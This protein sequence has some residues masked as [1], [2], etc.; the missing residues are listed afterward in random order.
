VPF[1]RPCRGPEVALRSYVAYGEQALSI[2]IARVVCCVLSENRWRDVSVVG[3]LKRAIRCA[4]RS[5]RFAGAFPRSTP[6]IHYDMKPSPLIT[7][8]FLLL[9]TASVAGVAAVSLGADLPEKSAK[10]R[11][12]E[13]GEALTPSDEIEAQVRKR[14]DSLLTTI[15]SRQWTNRSPKGCRGSIQR[16]PGIKSCWLPPPFPCVRHKG[17]ASPCEG[18]IFW[19]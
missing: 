8:S 16:E 12:P 19:P 2:M 4:G 10:P 6:S 18:G 3:S 11:Y 9:F 1:H 15:R 17:I 5:P 7:P 13:W 14:A